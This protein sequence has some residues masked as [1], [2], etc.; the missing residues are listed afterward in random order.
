MGLKGNDATKEEPILDALEIH[1][2]FRIKEIVAAIAYKQLVQDELGL[3]FYIKKC[4]EVRATY[5]FRAV[6][7]M[8]SEFNP[9]WVEKQK[10]YEKCI[11]VGDKLGP[12]D[13]I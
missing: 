9:P 13:V 10:G 6:S 1:C 5:T 3:P 2:K 7:D 4:K 11:E 12:A 8:F